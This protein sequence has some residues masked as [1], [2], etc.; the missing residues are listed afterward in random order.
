[1]GSYKSSV[2][3]P[4]QQEQMVVAMEAAMK[5][6]EAGQ[7]GAC[8]KPDT[9]SFSFSNMLKANQ[10][11]RDPF[12]NID[13]AVAWARAISSQKKRAR[14]SAPEGGPPPLQV[15]ARKFLDK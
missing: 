11:P 14:S 8:Y 4:A 6:P 5:A 12:D 13:M 1:M 10:L 9:R 7:A 2:T 3:T 15:F